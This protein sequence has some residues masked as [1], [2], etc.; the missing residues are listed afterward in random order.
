MSCLRCQDLERALETRQSQY[1]EVL[2]S[3]YFWVSREFAAYLSVELERAK[4]ELEEHRLVCVSVV[5]EPAA[6][7]CVARPRF[8][9]E[10]LRG[11]WSE[12]AV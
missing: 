3:T 7:W 6:L 10:Q 5:K 12:T 9:Q 8:A 11:S 4:N 1:S 2:A